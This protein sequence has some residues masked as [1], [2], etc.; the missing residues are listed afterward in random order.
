MGEKKRISSSE[1]GKIGMIAARTLR[2]SPFPGDLITWIMTSPSKIFSYNLFV[3]ELVSHH[4]NH[5]RGE[6]WRCLMSYHVCVDMSYVLLKEPTL[7]K[8]EGRTIHDLITYSSVGMKI[9]VDSISVY[10]A[11]IE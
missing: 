5:E 6:M 7:D 8:F 3:I 9:D 10:R 11:W 2:E 4:E 1:S